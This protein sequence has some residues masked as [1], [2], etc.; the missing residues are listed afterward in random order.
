MIGIYIIGVISYSGIEKL[1]KKP[2]EMMPFR[3]TS[4]S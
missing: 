1:S 2:D 3:K 4:K